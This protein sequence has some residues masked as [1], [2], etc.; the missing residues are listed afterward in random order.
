MLEVA[1]IHGQDQV[2]AL[3]VLH[4]HLARAQ[5]R[6][7]IATALGSQ[8]GALIRR[9]ADMPVTG[10]GGVHLYPLSQAGR[11]QT[12]PEHAFGSR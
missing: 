9:L 2:E 12:L 10:A 1:V 3:E 5:R 6:Q 7:V 4:R 11:L 8:A